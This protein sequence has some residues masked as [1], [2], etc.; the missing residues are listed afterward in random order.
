M[1]NSLRL[2]LTIIFIG[3]AIGPLLLV[4]VIL[5][6]RSF[7]VEG[8]QALDLQHQV[9]QRISAEVD[10]YLQ[11]IENNIN[12]IVS[13]VRDLE[14][15]DR[16]QYIGLLLEA[17]NSGAFR[18]VY[19]GFVL[20]DGQG[21]E[22]LRLSRQE[23]VP[24]DE[25]G[26]RSGTPEYERPRVTRETYFSPV[27]FDETTGQALMTI[28]IPFSRP[29]S[30][31][32]QGVLVTNIRF[33]TIGE[34]I[35]EL[36][37]SRGQTIYIVD[38]NGQV[39]AHQNT[40]VELPELQFEVP[41]ADGSQTGLAG[42]Q[43][44]LGFDPIQLGE[45]ELTVIAER[46]ES[47]ALEAATNT[48]YTIV[49]TIVGALILAGGLG[50][51]IVRQIVR[52]IEAMSATAQAVS[53]GDLSRQVDVPG[54]DEIGTLAR[55]FNSMTAQLREL[56][57][58]LEQRVADRTLR[59]ESLAAIGSHLSATLDQ[60]TLLAEMV[61]QLKNNFGYYHTHIYLLDD[62]RQHLVVVEGAGE[63]G[64]EMKRLGHTIS[65]DAPISLVAQA[66]RTQEV[67]KIDNVH[68][69]E[70]WLPNPLLPDTRSELAAPM[71]VGGRVLGVLDVQSDRI[72]Y[73]TEEDVR[74][75]TTLAA[76]VAVALQN[77]RLFTETAQR[78]SELELL[79]QVSR[80]LSM[81]LDPNQLIA[82][83][84]EQ[85][86]VTFS[87]YYTQIYLFDEARENLVSVGGRSET[88]QAVF[89]SQ[90]SLRTGRGLVGRAAEENE[91]V[92]VPD[93]RRHV[94]IEV[95]N[96]ANLE[97]IYRREAE[98]A[99][100]AEW[101]AKFIA[102]Y[103]GDV[104]EV[105]E[106][107][108]A[109]PDR[110][111]TSLKIGYVTHVPG[112]FPT[113]LRRGV[114]AA[115][116]DLQVEVELVTP[117]REGEH[118]PLFETMVRR[119]MDGLVVIPDQPG[120]VEPIQQAITAGI[121]V[122]TANRDLR[123]SSALMHV[124]VD[125]YQA[126][127]LLTRELVKLLQSEGKHEGKVLV[128][129]GIADRNAAVRQSLQD[130]NYM[131]VEI[132]GFLE[133]EAF[134]ET[135]WAQA[136]EDHHD[137]IAVIGLTALEP[138][139]LA[140]IKRNTRGQWL[141]AG[142]DLELATLEAIRDG[143]V[144]VTIG[145]HPYL[146]AYLPVLALVEHLH[147]DR[148]LQGWIAEGWLPNPTLPET[149]AEMA[150]PIALGDQVLGVLDV[151][152]KVANSLKSE[153][154]NLLRSV[155]DQVAVALTN[156]RLFEQALQTKEE[157]E[158][159]KEQ[160]EAANKNLE[161]Q[162]WQ[163]TGQ[164]QLSDQMRGE[165]DIHTLANSIIQQLCYYLQ[166]QIGVLYVVEGQYF[167]PMGR[168]AYSDLEPIESFE[169]GEGLVGQTALEM[170]PMFVTDVPNDYLIVRSGLGETVPRNIVLF[171]FMYND[172]VIGV[173]ELG[174]L[175][176]FSQA[177][178]EFIEIAL[179]S[180][181]IVF[182]TAQARAQIDELLVQTQQQAEDLQAQEEELRVANEELETQTESLRISESKLKEQQSQ[183]EATNIQLEEKAAAL[184]ESS[185]TL[186]EKQS[187][188]DKQNQELKG[189]QQELETRAEELARAS[190]YKSEFLANMS[191]ELRTPLNSLLI[192][193]R[194]LADNEEG[195]LTEDQIESAQIIYNGGKDLLTLINDILDLAKVEAGKLTFNIEPLSL[196]DMAMMTQAQFSPLAQEKGLEL[197][198]SLAEAL[199]A[200]IETDPQR[201]KQII[202]NMLSNAF[203][204]TSEGQVSLD[205]GRPQAGV[206]L[207]ASELDPAEAIAISVSDTGIGM[208]PEQQKIIFEA[209]QQ[210][211]GST[212]RQYGGTGLGLSI[213]RE[214]AAK[215]GGQI[216]VESEVGKGSVFTL[217]LPVAAPAGLDEESDK[218]PEPKQA[219]N[220]PDRHPA[221]MPAL[222][223]LP[224]DRAE[225]EADDKIL[226]VIEDDARFA[227]I[228]YGFAHKKGFKCVMASSGQAGLELVKTHSPEAVI[229]DLNL[230]DI[231][232]WDVLASLKNEPTT[233]HI[234]VH[235]ISAEEEDLEAFRKG[236][237][238]YLTKPV[239][240]ETLA[241]SFQ[242]IEEFSAKEI[243]ALL[244]VEDDANARASIKKLLGGS[245]VHI[246]EADRGET[247]LELL[248]IQQFDCM[249]LDLSLPDMSGFEVLAK[250][251]GHKAKAR[252]PVI[253]YTGQELTAEE[254]TE[255]RQYADSVIVKG[256]KS[257]ER[258]LDETALFLHRVVAEMPKDKQQTIK[259]LY[260][261]DS[262]L[263]DRKVLIV[264]DD[265]RNSFALSKL[266]SE[267]G[268]Q[269]R[270]AQDGQKALDLLAKEE[271]DLVLMDIMMPVMDGYETMKVI[272]SQP[273]YKSLP[274]L[275]LT[276][277]AMKGDREKCLE[278]GANDYL[279]K[280]IDVD[281]LF[282]M[283]RVW[284]YQ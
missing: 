24:A 166:A 6:E 276:A 68:E 237:I 72:G 153:N 209:F 53:T 189:A 119:K 77:A 15:P 274:I 177:Q 275:A 172:R 207:S 192:L 280:P 64:V 206:D 234:P 81:V 253:V 20:L 263:K 249:I 186:E 91:V 135:Y 27:W 142:F 18:D 66:A 273:E 281:R 264:D 122:V 198:I 74:I 239:S 255:L 56:V 14:Q 259:Q 82:E 115:A 16:S 205:I 42:T 170:R 147:Q 25:L 212:N 71:I 120:W 160:A 140:E 138:P 114:E 52:P 247:A 37:V 9:A 182:N 97:E 183:L 196:S 100:E 111:G 171:P 252:C 32:L 73:F 199:P 240:Q 107:L 79:S 187:I 190:K 78:A 236:A 224:D 220:Q 87:Y 217:Y 90:H 46:P 257:P 131:L 214:L 154:A 248:K 226:L 13:E 215:L 101:Y 106:S 93:V 225:L 173:I 149:K 130:T 202:K 201:V 63:P 94:G 124:G 47:E 126:A 279:P 98:P 41:D 284:L 231:S 113:M 208:A 31:E 57:S 162:I 229:L 10:T 194:I 179:A 19:E 144:Q 69:T 193:A 158:Q 268:M 58:S 110:T 40:S 250:M 228:V 50:F 51:L 35:S 254:N 238:G 233:R 203:K 89:T 43:V 104:K 197:K 271:V 168:Y 195:N 222:A 152:H 184:E 22:Q 49:A 159:A 29:R 129:T 60:E 146:Q 270:I 235:I 7:E 21:Q 223:F 4:G 86:S 108:G 174:T 143:T 39:I 211:D 210:A 176:D 34:L 216:E 137:C 278:A 227:K 157:A 246:S 36:Q 103:F 132:E 116:R 267:K 139:I 117:E 213:S 200:S 8:E 92:L 45:Q 33:D 191:H 204:F 109:H 269:I 178:L 134:L 59:L 150:V 151:Q 17:I 261:K 148:S 75:Q 141:L 28:A 3:L 244:L 145:Q 99:V 163:T 218:T 161:V 155:A 23:I 84:V 128:G 180:I 188:L 112:V 118:L 80:R 266:L 127:L 169:F 54:R 88:G 133:N 230:P 165:Q 260:D 242:T 243:K 241:K 156:A 1:R 48:V 67:I 11:E 83:V 232:G 185:L 256:V 70:H 30:V 283:L 282:S 167:V 262:M 95:V 181:A 85:V 62:S 12:L 96:R 221:A 272:R 123:P 44:V 277:K 175:G 102:N 245:D 65:I 121:P 136:I 5:A 55:A 26:D 164:A 219:S 2:R 61:S 38:F 76:Q 258:L 251:N 125:N 105:R 265:V